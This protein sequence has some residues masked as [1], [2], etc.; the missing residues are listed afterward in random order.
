[1]VNRLLSKPLQIYEPLTARQTPAMRVFFYN[2]YQTVYENFD[3]DKD[4]NNSAQNRR[5][6][7]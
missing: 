3:A 1:M 5:L 4:E 2:L 6:V 7:R